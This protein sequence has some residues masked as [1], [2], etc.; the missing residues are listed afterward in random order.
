MD[1]RQTITELVIWDEI[2]IK[3]NEQQLLNCQAVQ[4]A[5][6]DLKVEDEDSCTA[7]ILEELLKL[8]KNIS[9]KDPRITANL[10]FRLLRATYKNYMITT[11]VDM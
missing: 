6:V 1:V 3:L 2:T 11:K 9:V 7:E 5:F 4:H 10:Y 8:T